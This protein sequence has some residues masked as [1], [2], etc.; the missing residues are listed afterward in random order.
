MSCSEIVRYHESGH[1]VC[2]I[3]LGIALKAD[4]IRCSNDDDACTEVEDRV[5]QSL[6]QE[7]YIRRAAVKMAGPAA[8]CRLRDQAFNSDTLRN[9]QHYST[10]YQQA[11]QILQYFQSRAGTPDPAALERQM[12]EAM[13]ICHRIISDRWPDV[14]KV[15]KSLDGR[16]GMTAREIACCLEVAG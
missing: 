14:E 13:A 16:D 5:Q 3:E 12:C 2:A 7:D 8:E 4:G 11:Q 6:T 9:E 10:D 15:A 1:A